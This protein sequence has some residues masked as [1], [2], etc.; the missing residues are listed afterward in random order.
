MPLQNETCRAR[1]GK[2]CNVIFRVGL[3]LLIW[4]GATFDVFVMQPV[5]SKV[6]VMRKV[7]AAL[8]ELGLPMT[9]DRRVT[10]VYYI[11]YV[12]F[13]DGAC[14]ANTVRYLVYLMLAEWRSPSSHS[15]SLL[16]RRL[17]WDAAVS[18]RNRVREIMI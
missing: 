17:S 12:G 4:S 2:A 10:V 16:F 18:A 6:M 9:N 5:L 13:L 14:D 7:R 11:A 1:P 8:R 3:V 15:R